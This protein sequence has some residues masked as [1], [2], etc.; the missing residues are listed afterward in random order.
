M[1]PERGSSHRR[2]PARGSL[3]AR[4]HALR[5]AHRPPALRREGPGELAREAPEGDRR[6]TSA[7]SCPDAPEALDRLIFELMAK[8][9]AR[10]P[11]RRPPGAGRAR[12]SSR[13]RSASRCRGSSTRRRPPSRARR[14]RSAST[15]R[16]GTGS[17]SS[18]A[19]SPRASRAGR[20]SSLARTLDAIRARVREVDEL[21]A[22][23]LRASSSSSSQVERRGPRR[24]P[25]P[26]PRDGGAHRRRLSDA[27]GGAGAARAGRA[28][29]GGVA[30]ASSP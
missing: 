29:L 26:R 22:R 13:A 4:R 1:A 24:A 2:G 3:R 27:R 14:A 6:R 28:A 8:D 20:R 5:D 11:R 19:C 17:R 21:R 25:P 12:R 15:I 16:G 7:A 9:P 30:R 23:G 10:A 18:S